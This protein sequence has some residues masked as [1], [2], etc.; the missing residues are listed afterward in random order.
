[1]NVRS[2]IY[3][4]ILKSIV[5]YF[6]TV[7]ILVFFNLNLKKSNV[8]DVCRLVDRF[9]PCRARSVRGAGHTSGPHVEARAGPG[10]LRVR[11]EGP[12]GS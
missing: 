8:G 9:L 1:M 12:Q 4:L 3:M 5:L 10:H 7:Y 2:T 11:A 6:Y